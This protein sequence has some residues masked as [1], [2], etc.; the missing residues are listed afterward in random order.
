MSVPNSTAFA[1]GRIDFAETEPSDGA[2]QLAAQLGPGHCGRTADL[3][4]SP[5]GDAHRL[6]DRGSC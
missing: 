4:V 3:T 5:M 1:R 6:L 2:D